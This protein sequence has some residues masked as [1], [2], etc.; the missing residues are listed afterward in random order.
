MPKKTSKQNKQFK[1]KYGGW[2]EIKESSVPV[3]VAKLVKS[4][5]PQISTKNGNIVIRHREYLMDV[6]TVANDLHIHYREA[7]PG[8][9]SFCPWLSQIANRFE[10]YTFTRLSFEYAPMCSSATDG[11]LI[12]AP[13]YDVSDYPPTDVIGLSSYP[14]AIHTPLWQPARMDCD[15]ALLQKLVRERI[16]RSEDI[17]DVD[18]KLYDALC[19][20]VATTGNAF[21]GTFGSIWV[22]YE[23]ILR[24]PSMDTTVAYGDSAKLTGGAAI[25]KANPLGTGATVV[26]GSAQMVIGAE[27]STQMK[28]LRAGQYLLQGGVAGTGLT[29][30]GLD[31][32]FA[33]AADGNQVGASAALPNATATSAWTDTWVNILRPCWVT[34]AAAVG[35]TT[36]TGLQLRVMPYKSSLA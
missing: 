36:L 31:F 22:D 12:L 30:N 1:A 3:A 29:T 4:T 7:N 21:N 18:M 20:Y 13:D 28:F 26:N 32:T 17:D 2:E 9:Y 8:L 14:G 19:I 11:K 35:W 33:S 27:S 5:H 23:V 25:D 6:D 10:S 15:P 24:T 16:I 34:V